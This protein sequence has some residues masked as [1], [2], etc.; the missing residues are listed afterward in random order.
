MSSLEVICYHLITNICDLLERK[1]F[2]PP[3]RP[4]KSLLR[5]TETHICLLDAHTLPPYLEIG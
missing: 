5:V 2:V 1:Y 3:V 4:S